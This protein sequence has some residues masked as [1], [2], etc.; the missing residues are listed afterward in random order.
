MI[1][2][3][4]EKKGI[5]GGQRKRVNL[6]MELLTDPSLLFLDEPTSGLSSQDTLVVMDVLRKFADGGK[7]I[8]LTIHQPSLEAYK[9]MDNVI[10]LSSGKLMYYGPAHPD[11]LTFFNP[12]IH[13]EKVTDNADN[14][15]KGL[16]TCSEEEWQREYKKSDYYK[17]Y[18]EERK[19]QECPID[20][21]KRQQISGHFNL[22][23]WWTL[24]CRYFAVKRKDIVN[25]AIL[26][27]QA[28]V[29]AILIALA[30]HGDK[31]LA[32]IPLL[33]TF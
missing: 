15:L 8:I 6:A 26:L 2:G 21:K 16:A 22:R 28:P 5:S 33:E 11:S 14:A 13:P 7:T 12:G 10:I 9:K 4:A 31:N 1:I 32:T 18:V 30:F 27:L 20:W 23:Q 29:I 19:N 3:S 24:T 17:N 25:T